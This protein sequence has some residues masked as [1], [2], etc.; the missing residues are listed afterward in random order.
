MACSLSEWATRLLLFTQRHRH[1]FLWI[2]R[3]NVSTLFFIVLF[4][5]FKKRK[6]IEWPN[7]LRENGLCLFILG[8]L[9]CNVILAIK[10]KWS[11]LYHS[12]FSCHI[13]LSS[14]CVCEAEC[15]HKM[16]YYAIIQKKLV[17][18]KPQNE[19]WIRDKNLEQWLCIFAKQN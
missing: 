12:L 19:K 10:S 16:H 3:F 17:S 5:A 18:V 11:S 9:V 7:C 13:S 4:A 2:W 6:K 15:P 8:R 14:V 1:S